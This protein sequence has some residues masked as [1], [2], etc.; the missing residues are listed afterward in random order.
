MRK[1]AAPFGM[2]LL[3]HDGFGNLRTKTAKRSVRRRPSNGVTDK[4]VERFLLTI[5]EIVACV[6]PDF[7]SVPQLIVA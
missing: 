3:Q 6:G 2:A 4:G 7:Q 5:A 1:V